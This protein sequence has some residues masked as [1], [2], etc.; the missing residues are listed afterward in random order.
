MSLVDPKSGV[1]YLTGERLIAAHVNTVFAQQPRALDAV[2]GGTYDVGDDIILNDDGGSLQFS[3]LSV[4]WTGTTNLP[5]LGSRTMVRMQRSSV[6]GSTSFGGTPDFSVSPITGALTQGY[7]DA[8]GTNDPSC[9]F[10]LDNMIDLATLTG[11]F[12]VIDPASSSPPTEQPRMQVIKYPPNV[13]AS[14]VG[15][16]VADPITGSA[17]GNLH[18]FGVTGL[19]EAINQSAASRT[20]YVARFTGES[21]SG[22][23][24]GLLIQQIYC[25]FT[26]TKLTPG[27]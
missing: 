23:T 4:T 10:S 11:V 14:L 2:D 26:V 21:G 17:Y 19:S 12:V 22:A 20:A 24:A 5:S 8:S 9:I 7:V 3:G 25:L 6:T 27:G 16:E 1:G 13:S 18:I 15:G